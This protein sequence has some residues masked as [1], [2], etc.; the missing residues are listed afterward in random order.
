[1][2]SIYLYACLTR[3]IRFIFYI[4]VNR[5][6]AENGPPQ[7]PKESSIYVIKILDSLQ[8]SHGAILNRWVIKNIGNVVNFNFIKQLF[9][10]VKDKFLNKIIIAQVNMPKSI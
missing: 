8:I 4:F 10:L 7:T 5:N 1:M 3:Y 9:E 2:G 6:D